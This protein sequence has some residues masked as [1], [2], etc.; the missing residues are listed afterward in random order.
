LAKPT[1][2][3]VGPTRRAALVH[4]PGHSEMGAGLAAL[5]QLETRSPPVRPASN[6][7]SIRIQPPNVSGRPLPLFCVAECH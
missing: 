4:P 7:S 6:G 3:S 1:A 5:G 2:S